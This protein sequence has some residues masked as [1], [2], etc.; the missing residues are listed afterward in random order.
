MENSWLTD[1][2][3]FFRYHRLLCIF[4]DNLRP[5]RRFVFEFVQHFVQYF[6][7]YFGL[8]PFRSGTIIIDA[9]AVL[10]RVSLKERL[11][12][13]VGLGH[14]LLFL[15]LRS[16]LPHAIVLATAWPRPD[17]RVGWPLVLL[18]TRRC[19]L[20]DDLGVVQ[21]LTLLLVSERNWDRL[22]VSIL[23]GSLL[24]WCGS[25]MSRH[26]VEIILDVGVAGRA[27]VYHRLHLLELADALCALPLYGFL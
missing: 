7:L 24:L 27:E 19:S 17:R 8:L 5:E 10:W 15:L 18:F 12:C 25:G 11:C 13:G 4:G 1:Y 21:K 2:L 20:L 16:W 3:D 9:A 23:L 6:S 26:N 22:L 14:H